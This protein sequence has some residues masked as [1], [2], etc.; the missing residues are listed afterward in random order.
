MAQGP[1]NIDNTP[2]DPE[3]QAL[4]LINP[5]DALIGTPVRTALSASPKASTIVL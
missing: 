3:G 1:P 4:G 2:L 5:K